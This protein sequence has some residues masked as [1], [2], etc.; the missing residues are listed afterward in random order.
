MMKEIRT[1][2]R[3][4]TPVEQI[5]STLTDF[6]GYKNWNTALS[7][8]EGKLER[9]QEFN[10][11]L[12]PEC[13]STGRLQTR[14]DVIEENRKLI[15]NT[16]HVGVSHLFGFQYYLTLV[17]RSRGRVK[18]LHGAIFWG[19]LLPLCWSQISKENRAQFKQANENLQLLFRSQE[20][21]AKEFVA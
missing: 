6:E 13:I 7:T 10:L 19:L 14:L 5:W 4:Y 12:N 17:P 8:V 20:H 1:S 16:T 18:L 15:W 9:H 11:Q 3:L 21:K 2:T